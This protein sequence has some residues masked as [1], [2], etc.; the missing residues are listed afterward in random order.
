MQNPP[1]PPIPLP[2]YTPSPAVPR[3]QN[4]RRYKLAK[5]PNIFIDVYFRGD[6]IVYYDID[7]QTGTGRVAR[8]LP[9]SNILRVFVGP[10]GSFWYIKRD[11]SGH[12]YN[13]VDK[14]ERFR[15]GKHTWIPF[16]RRSKASE[17]DDE[18][19]SDD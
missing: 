15:N 14:A 2:T 12:Y 8:R 1:P 5:N 16:S 13:G 18:N 7:P 6:S 3:E 19:D 17:T 9:P 4:P 10:D 11:G